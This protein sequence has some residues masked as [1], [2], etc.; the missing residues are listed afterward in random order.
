MVCE[1]AIYVRL[2]AK[3]SLNLPTATI[4]FPHHDHHHSHYLPLLSQML[5]SDIH[6]LNNTKQGTGQERRAIEE[7]RKD[8][9]HIPNRFSSGKTAVER[10]F[11]R[12]DR[13]KVRTCCCLIFVRM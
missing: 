11:A 8:T 5:R 2:D 13:T 6:K 7:S 3:Y 4:M 10:R 9:E 1:C 12:I